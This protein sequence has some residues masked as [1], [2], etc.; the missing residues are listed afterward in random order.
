M[1][2]LDIMD[3]LFHRDRLSNLFLYKSWELYRMEGL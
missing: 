1:Q 3:I 2:Q